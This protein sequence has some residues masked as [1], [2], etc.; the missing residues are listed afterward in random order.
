MDPSFGVEWQPL[1]ARGCAPSGHQSVAVTVDWFWL[2]RVRVWYTDDLIYK[3]PLLLRAR[4]ETHPWERL[5]VTM[6]QT[7]PPSTQ[8]PQLILWH[9]RMTEFCPLHCRRYRPCLVTVDS[10]RGRWR[11]ASARHLKEILVDMW[12][13]GEKGPLG[14]I[15][16]CPLDLLA[17]SSSAD[18]CIKVFRQIIF[19][20]WKKNCCQ[21][22]ITHW[23]PLECIIRRSPAL[24]PGWGI[25]N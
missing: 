2:A 20:K 5:Q 25:C 11:L 21:V 22:G 17:T 18:K 9:T 13:A 6:S 4:A 8:S 10:P 19:S 3:A 12:V 1:V 16:Y 24:G 7:F 15:R 14:V 23:L